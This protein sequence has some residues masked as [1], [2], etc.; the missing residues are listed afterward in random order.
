MTE[1]HFIG[2]DL[3]TQQV[4]A[5]L[6]N[7]HN[8]VVAREAV[9]FGRHLAEYK[10]RDGVHFG[11]DG[12]TV[13]S[14]VVM[15]LHAIDDV[16]G[17]L[18]AGKVDLRTVRGISGC[19]QQHG[20]VYWATGAEAILKGL[21]KEQT[22]RDGL[23]DAFSTQ[24]SPIW[25]DSSTDEECSALEAKVG[26]AEQ[27]CRLTG[28]RAHQRFSGP[29]IKKMADKSKEIWANTERVSIVSSFLTSIF[30]G[31][32]EGVDYT[33]GSGT[34][35]MDITTHQWIPELLKATSEDLPDKLGPL[36]PPSKVVGEICNYLHQRYGI[37][38]SCRILPFLGDNPAS[39]AGLAMAVGDVGI[40]LGTSDTLFFT[41]NVFNPSVDAHVFSHFQ[42]PDVFMPL[43][44][45]KNGSLTRER[46]R[47][48][49]GVDWEGFSQVLAR[50]KPGNNGN[51]GFFFDVDEIVPR[52]RKGD[53][54]FGDFTNNDVA[55][56]AVFEGQCLLKRFYAEKMGLKVPSGGRLLVTGGA[57]TNADLQQMLANVFDMPVY[58]NDVVDS[59]ALG[60]AMRARYDFYAPSCTYEEY[61]TDV[62]FN[63]VA[64][65]DPAAHL[66]YT[67]LMEKFAELIETL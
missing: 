41:T 45:F 5:I 12:M 56:R 46:I 17:R 51:L 43:V 28:S 60:G 20:T 44:C 54:L 57:S 33:D 49:A 14:P 10:S 22:L 24:N 31:R 42:N 9:N 58:V 29:Q 18:A 11:D 16:L 40:S 6:L 62:K 15:W 25:M 53:R 2:I 8:R 30:T 4:K 7:G 66:I 47:A 63:K 38:A 23:K 37:N 50:T 32:Y 35:L 27:L 1:D 39:L 26:G 19:A 65:P 3:S 55:A 21:K 52:V 13:T 34:N 67:Q 61:Y 59:A 64:D 36:I 48:Q